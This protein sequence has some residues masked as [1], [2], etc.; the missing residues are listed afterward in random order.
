MN[1]A[2]ELHA[3]SMSLPN[4][5]HGIYSESLLLGDGSMTDIYE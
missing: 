5:L 4:K 3:I 2:F 1:I